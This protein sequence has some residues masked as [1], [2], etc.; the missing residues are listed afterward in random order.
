MHAECLTFSR[1]AVGRVAAETRGYHAGGN[2]K[3]MGAPTPIYLVRH[4]PPSSRLRPGHARCLRA[5]PAIE[6]GD[7]ITGAKDKTSHGQL[8]PCCIEA[9]GIDCQR[10]AQI[11]MNLAKLARTHGRALVEKLPPFRAGVVLAQHVQTAGWA[12]QAAAASAAVIRQK[13]P[14]Q[15]CCPRTSSFNFAMHF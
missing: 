6:I 11:Y 15:R 5:F 7:I 1:A 4:R 10:A 12:R 14:P 9:L 2:S 13:R 8:G 3:Q